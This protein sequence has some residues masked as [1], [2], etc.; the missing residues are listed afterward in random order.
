MHSE[1]TNYV[2]CYAIEP[3]RWSG[4]GE[5]KRQRMGQRELCLGN[6]NAARYLPEPTTTAGRPH[7]CNNNDNALV[8]LRHGQPWRQQQLLPGPAATAAT[9]STRIVPQKKN[10]KTT[11]NKTK[12][13]HTRRSH[14]RPEPGVAGLSLCICI[15]ACISAA[16]VSAS[17]AGAVAAAVATAVN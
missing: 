15:C 4:R 10:K 9:R 8:Y 17:Q 14:S 6:D 13:Q 2:E 12:R 16:S 5:G 3:R 7:L 1:L 11:K